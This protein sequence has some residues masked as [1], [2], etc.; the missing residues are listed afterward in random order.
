MVEFLYMD[1]TSYKTKL[2]EEKA[3]LEGELS[4]VGRRN[5]SNPADW[6]AVAPDPEFRPDPNE[7]ADQMAAYGTNDSILTDL[8]IRYNEVTDALSRIEAGTY[9]TCKVCGKDI[10]TDRLG[11]DPSA[12]TCKEHIDQ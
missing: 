2:E 11:A 6:E 8:E 7:L 10:E 5:P 12:D 1:T 3:R 4:T 9:G